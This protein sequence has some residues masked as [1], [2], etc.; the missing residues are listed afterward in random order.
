MIHASSTS[1]MVHSYIATSITKPYSFNYHSESIIKNVSCQPI[2]DGCHNLADLRLQWPSRPGISNLLFLGTGRQSNLHS[3]SLRHSPGSLRSQRL[4]SHCDHICK[5]S[6]Q[7]HSHRF[8]TAAFAEVFTFSM[9]A[10]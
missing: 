10:R 4:R 6:K 5:R 3:C 2:V 9:A 8:S 7:L 1:W